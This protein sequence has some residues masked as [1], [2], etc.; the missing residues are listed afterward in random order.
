MALLPNTNAA[1]AG[2]L[3]EKMRACVEELAIRHAHSSAGPVV[4]ISLGTATFDPADDDDPS[5]LVQRADRALYEAKKAGR[6]RVGESP[7]QPLKAGP[8]ADDRPL[9]DLQ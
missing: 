8:T 5:G 9:S 1:G 6:N 2:K 4:T 7:A 3:A